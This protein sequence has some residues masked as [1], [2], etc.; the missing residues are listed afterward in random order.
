VLVGETSSPYRDRAGITSLGTFVRNLPRDVLCA[1]DVWAQHQYPGDADR[2]NEL[3]GL[4]RAR[5]CPNGRK[6]IWITETGAGREGPG[7][8]R[9]ADPAVLRA[10]CRTM[11][12]SLARWYRD[13]DIDAAFQF[14]FHEDPNFAVGLVGPAYDREYPTYALWR[15]W[16]E[17]ADAADPPPDLPAQCR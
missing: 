8:A 15:A 5:P 3:E 7:H 16:G 10:G 2:L 12:R 1:G 11:N 17:R 4:L 6:R 14:T 9:S 13:P